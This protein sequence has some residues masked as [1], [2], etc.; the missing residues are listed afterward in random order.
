MIDEKPTDGTSTGTWN[1]EVY[2]FLRGGSDPRQRIDF[3]CQ[4][5]H[6]V[7]NVDFFWTEFSVQCLS[8]V[9]YACSG[10]YS[11]YDG[12]S[13]HTHSPVARTFFCT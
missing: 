8:G 1:D 10:D 6:G 11:V 5:G 3:F 9:S 7:M 13:F 12:V 4:D 2:V